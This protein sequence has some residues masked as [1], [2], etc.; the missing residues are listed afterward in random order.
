MDVIVNELSSA[1]KF[2]KFQEMKKQIKVYPSENS[3]GNR[4]K[5]WS[6]LIVVF[7]FKATQLD[8]T[9]QILMIV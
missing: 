8:I 4:A 1:A 9:Q 7:I 3:L 5:K 6:S 2:F